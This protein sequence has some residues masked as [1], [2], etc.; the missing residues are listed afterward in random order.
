MARPHHQKIGLV[1][2]RRGE[3]AAGAEQHRERERHG[4]G[5]HSLGEAECDR[6]EQDRGGV[7]GE[8]VGEYRYQQEQHRQHHGG[9]SP[10]GQSDYAVGEIG[11]GTGLH[12]RRAERERGPHHQEDAPVERVGRLAQRQHAGRQ[13]QRYAHQRRACDRQDAERRRRNRRDEDDARGL[14]RARRRQRLG[15]AVEHDQP[16]VAAQAFEGFTPALDDQHVALAQHAAGKAAADHVGTPLDPEHETAEA[17]PEA[18]LLQRPADQARARRDHDLGHHL[19]AAE[20]L[21]AL[22]LVLGKVFAGHVEHQVREGGL[23]RTQGIAGGEDHERVAVAD[24][25]VAER[26]HVG[27]LVALHQDQAAAPDSE[28]VEACL[29]A[30]QLRIRRRP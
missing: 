6:C 19:V 7:V 13:H 27:M 4:M 17:R 20:P 29:L 21:L 11:G 24:F 18:G 1:A 28:Q 30:D 12:H 23:G 26:R 14:R 9:P 16:A 3:R 2:D 15:R 22:L 8:Y 10:A 25:Q 5:V